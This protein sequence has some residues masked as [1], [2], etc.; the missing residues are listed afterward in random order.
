MTKLAR[1]RAAL[2]DLIA[3]HEAAGALPTSARFLFYE[4]IQRAVIT[5]ERTGARRPDQDMSD[6]LT[7]LRETGE[8]PWDAI[9]DETR[10]LDS[11][12]TAP[13]VAQWVRDGLKY[14]RIGPWQD[15]APPLI[16]CESRS[17][18]G[19]L[20]RI[21]F[22][23]AVPIASTNGQCSGFLHTD[24]APA[25]DDGTRVIYLGDLDLA[26]SQIEAN[27]RSVIE[28]H[29]G[30]LVWE[31]LAITAEQVAEHGLPVIPKHDRRY[32]DGRRHDAV[33]T[34]ALSQQVLTRMLTGHLDDLLPEPLEDVQERERAERAEVARIL[35]QAR[36]R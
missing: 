5:K 19:V 35:R 21:A 16:L 25:C 9:V 13:T 1:L 10:S 27:T 8:V 18:A 7:Q 6:A 33:E 11:V 32:R 26:G 34:E 2:R 20:R 23:Y 28:S 24:I 36:D 4:L 31:R 14:A 3:E 22:M 29:T 12:R 30:P 15:S 17:L